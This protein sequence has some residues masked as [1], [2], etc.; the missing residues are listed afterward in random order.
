MLLLHPAQPLLQVAPLVEVAL[1]VDPLAVAVPSVEA[2]VAAF[3]IG[4]K[5]QNR[6]YNDIRIF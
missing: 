5:R 1:A 3:L 2:A 6:F 4:K